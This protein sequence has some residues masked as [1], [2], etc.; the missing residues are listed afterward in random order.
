MVNLG[1]AMVEFTGAFL[2]HPVCDGFSAL[3]GG[4]GGRRLVL[5]KVICEQFS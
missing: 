2:A 1:G 5:H 4:R 3:G